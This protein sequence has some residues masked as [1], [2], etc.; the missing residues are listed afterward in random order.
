MKRKLL[1]FT[2]FI[3]LFVSFAGFVFADS[4]PS[5]WAKG[6][7]E[8]ATRLNLLPE[9][10][11]TGY[12]APINRA[13]FCKLIVALYEAKVAAI[14]DKSTFA[15]T[16][17]E[18]VGKAAFVGLVNGVGENRF[19][20]G[21]LLTR[22]QAATILTNYLKTTGVQ[23]PAYPP[24]FRDSSNVSSWAKAAVGVMQS[25]GIM[26][27]SNDKFDPKG[28]YTLEQSVI[29]IV[30]TYNFDNVFRENV[31]KKRQNLNELYEIK[32]GTFAGVKLN[33]LKF[34]YSSGQFV[35]K[36]ML[37]NNVI[38]SAQPVKDMAQKNG[39]A[40]AVNGT[41]FDAYSGNPVPMGAIV[42]D[43]EVLY[44]CDSKGAVAFNKDGKALIDRLSIPATK[45]VLNGQESFAPWFVNRYNSDPSAI[46]LF[47]DEYPKTINVSNGAKAFVVKDDKVI[48][49]IGNSFTVAK[50]TSAVLMQPKALSDF[51]RYHEI[52]IGD[53]LK[54][55]SRFVPK[56]DDPA[57]WENVVTA[58]SAGP[59]L[60]KNGY[61]CVDAKAENFVEQKILSNSGGRTFIGITKN[62]DIVIG[63]CSATVNNL[64]KA[65]QAMGLDAATCLDGGA[66]TAIYVNGRVL[67][68]GR[69]VNNALGFVFVK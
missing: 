60:V 40:I 62:N 45:A 21:G 68:S 7:V 52:N 31:A 41:Y 24:T 11:R 37:A 51:N 10:L 15:D 39:A 8:E 35:A 59:L 4:G 26:Q 29:T 5:Y 65:C 36:T 16:D 18:A 33:Y 48:N 20:P 53:E 25:S 50:G 57:L 32:S 17:D 43:G 64:A 55:P 12:Q 66:S 27:G 67:T 9:S 23:L 47:T 2:V 19:N 56:F 13:N 44:T 63:Y 42:K 14:T 61:V 3:L 28:L 58:V 54:T 30:R 38:T 69:N 22:E 46:L 1:F 34:A 6:S 49:I